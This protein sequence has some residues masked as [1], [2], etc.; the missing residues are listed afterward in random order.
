MGHSAALIR[1]ADD[2]R[3]DL[4]SFLLQRKNIITMDHNAP[5]KF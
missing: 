4:V 1:R 5:P 2:I 3:A